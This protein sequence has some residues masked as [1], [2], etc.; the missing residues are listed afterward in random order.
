[1]AK[2]FIESKQICTN[3]QDISQIMSF[4]C[5]PSPAE[6]QAFTNS[7]ACLACY[8]TSAAQSNPQLCDNVCSFC[9]YSNVSQNSMINFSSSCTMTQEACSKMLTQVM[10][11]IEQKAKNREDSLGKA[12]G[13]LTSLAGGSNSTNVATRTKINNLIEN[14]L[15]VSNVQE[16]RNHLSVTQKISASG[17]HLNAISQTLSMQ[18]ISKAFGESKAGQE[19]NAMLTNIDKQTADN[20]LSGIFTVLSDLFKNPA[21]LVAAAAVVIVVMT[22]GSGEKSKKSD[23]Q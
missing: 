18:I 19:L 12:L 1:M 8:K 11:E 2:A 10:T 9:T 15:S 3:T 7:P 17:G 21:F 5:N 13:S 23:M 16:I 4:S 14:N 6:I 20:E 22:S